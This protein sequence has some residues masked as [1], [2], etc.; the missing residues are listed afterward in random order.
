MAATNEERLQRED[1][2]RRMAQKVRLFYC[3][4]VLIMDAIYICALHLFF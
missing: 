3:V 1:F 4:F 2:E